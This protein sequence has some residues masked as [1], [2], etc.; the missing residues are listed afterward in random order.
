MINIDRFEPSTIGPKQ[1]AIREKIPEQA[2]K[3]G[4]RPEGEKIKR[5]PIGKKEE[6]LIHIVSLLV[7]D[8]DWEKVT[9]I[10]YENRHQHL[11]AEMIKHYE[12]FYGA[13]K[14]L[15]RIKSHVQRK[16]KAIGGKETNDNVDE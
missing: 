12:D 16:R 9:K 8:D 7:V 11:S 6:E 2:H 1:G 14:L 4:K 15:N 10:A 5:P 3:S 13:S